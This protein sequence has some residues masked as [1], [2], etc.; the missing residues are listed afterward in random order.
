MTPPIPHNTTARILSNDAHGKQRLAVG[1]CPNP[2]AAFTA[3]ARQHD[4]QNSRRLVMTS[5]IIDH[6]RP[7]TYQARCPH[8]LSATN[9]RVATRGTWGRKRP[10]RGGEGTQTAMQLDKMGGTGRKPQRR[11][12]KQRVDTGAWPYAC[13][14]CATIPSSPQ[15]PR[16]T[17]C[18]LRSIPFW[19]LDL[20]GFTRGG[21]EHIRWS[22]YVCRV[23][24]GLQCDR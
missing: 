11:V 1:V 5:D 16:V 18:F 9:A 24:N 7:P 3:R 4:G 22:G 6:A 14:A 21:S 19:N 12:V 17:P 10:R 15:R 13:T 20:G 8:R 23:Y 2:A